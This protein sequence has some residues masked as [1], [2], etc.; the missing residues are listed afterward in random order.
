[1]AVTISD[2][3]LNVGILNMILNLGSGMKKEQLW[4]S[5][6]WR[7]AGTNKSEKIMYS[8]NCEIDCN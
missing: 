7:N 4:N 6:Q 5:A 2:I 8:W 3:I 1:M